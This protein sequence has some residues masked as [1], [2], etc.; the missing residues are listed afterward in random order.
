MAEMLGLSN[1]GPRVR[2][3]VR[4]LPIRLRCL[5]ILPVRAG[6]TGE[7]WPSPSYGGHR[8]IAVA[9]LELNRS[10]AS[11]PKAFGSK[12]G[13]KGKPRAAVHL[14]GLSGQG[15]VLA[16]LHNRTQALTLLPKPFLGEKGE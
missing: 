10:P 6:L 11:G 15:C 3:R 9:V 5:R 16:L 14:K 8:Q 12:P 2:T 13:G 7:Q 1:R 4:S